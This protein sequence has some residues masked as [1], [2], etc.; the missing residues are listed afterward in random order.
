[1]NVLDMVRSIVDLPEEDLVA[2]TLGTIVHV[3]HTPRL[4]YEV[5]FIDA[6]GSTI[7]MATVSPDQIV[8]VDRAE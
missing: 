8:A 1:V 4:A 2:G 7:A 5:E 3:F 6:A